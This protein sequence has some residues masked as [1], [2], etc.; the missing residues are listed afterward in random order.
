MHLAQVANVTKEKVAEESA[1]QQAAK[2]L[3][4][5]ALDPRLVAAIVDRVTSDAHILENRHPVLPPT[6]QQD[7]SRR[8]RAS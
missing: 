5:M 7:T 8:K 6:H 4:W 3:V 2:E 1:E